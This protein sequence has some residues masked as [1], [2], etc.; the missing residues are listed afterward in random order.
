MK[1]GRF[2][3]SRAWFLV[4]AVAVMVACA[5]LCVAGDS[6]IGG[7]GI[8]DDQ[9]IGGTGVL[10]DRGIGGTGIVGTITGFGSIL[11]NGFEVDVPADL[12]V[13]TD[14]GVV[15]PAVLRRGQVV[16]LTADPSGGRLTAR[17]LE[18]RHVVAGPVTA[19]DRSAGIVRVMGQSVRMTSDTLGDR[20]D[21]IRPGMALRISGLRDGAGEIHASRVDRLP[22]GRPD[23][24]TGAVTAVDRHGFSVAGVRIGRPPPSG[25]SV[26]DEVSV[27]GAYDGG[28]L[29]AAA[30]RLWPRVPFGGRVRTLSVEGYLARPRSGRGFRLDGMT[31]QPPAAAGAAPGQRVVI[32]GSVG[33]GDRFTVHEMRRWPGHGGGGAK[34]WP[35]DTGQ[36][37]PGVAK[38]P[39]EMA[40][41]QPT[42]SPRAGPAPRP[43]APSWSAAPTTRRYGEEPARRGPPPGSVRGAPE[44][45][46]MDSPYSRKRQRH[47]DWPEYQPGR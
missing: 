17:S 5:P 3:P 22:A 46:D 13:S 14:D 33:H 10:A 16:A 39:R 7:T 26:G 24:L 20:L 45:R 12:P 28:R 19:V 34:R 6:G 42:R 1:G 36:V 4:L 9:G 23:V 8:A 32:D 44:P 43:E 25:L 18:V 37:A 2:H 41:P 35:P 47:G 27:R 30:L 29:T 11:V 31:V 15:T 40:P 21:G 38:V